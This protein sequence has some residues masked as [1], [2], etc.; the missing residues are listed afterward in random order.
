MQGNEFN[1]HF[2]NLTGTVHLNK[3][4]TGGPI[5]IST[6]QPGI[7]L[8]RITGPNGFSAVSKIIKQAR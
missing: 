6:M 3:K 7:Y 8:L 1:V 5:D 4:T 2:S